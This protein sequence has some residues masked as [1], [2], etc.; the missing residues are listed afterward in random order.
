L[1]FWR[2]AKYR[3]DSQ[4]ICPN[5]YNLTVRTAGAGCFAGA[6][7]WAFGR[8]FVRGARPDCPKCSCFFFFLLLGFLPKFI[9]QVFCPKLGGLTVRSPSLELQFSLSLSVCP[10]WY[11]SLERTV[12]LGFH[13][14]VFRF[15]VF[16][17]LFCFFVCLFVRSVVRLFGLGVLLQFSVLVP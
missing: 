1:Q 10:V 15:L 8:S 2:S 16:C 6:S 14:L 4:V 13:F 12:R 7:S 11:S 9:C 5:P 3:Q 17:L